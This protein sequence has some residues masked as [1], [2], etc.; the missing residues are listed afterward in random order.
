MLNRRIAEVIGLIPPPIQRNPGR[1]SFRHPG[2]FKA[3]DGKSPDPSH[4]TLAPRYGVDAHGVKIILQGMPLSLIFLAK[5]S[6]GVIYPQS[7]LSSLRALAGMILQ[8][9]VVLLLGA[10]ASYAHDPYVSNTDIW[11][12]PDGCEI[13]IVMNRTLYRRLLDS[14]PSAVLSDENFDSLY[15]PLLVKCAPTL[16][17]ITVDGVK[18]EPRQVEVSLAEQTDLQFTFLYA[19]PAGTKFH[20]SA[21]FVKK[22]DVGFMN[23]L[24]MNES[25]NFLGY[26]EQTADKLAWEI[27]LPAA[28]GRSAPAN[29]PVPAQSGSHAAGIGAACATLAIAI[30][31]VIFLLRRKSPS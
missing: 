27:N 21:I 31:L 6:S 3:S 25:R 4:T 16:L 24:V 22:M 5:A 20:L 15:R 26:G 13:D 2:N 18:L 11:L 8:T 9:A 29:S 10:N 19:R 7:G 23:S 30:L 1:L 12:R 28:G 14:P 17:E